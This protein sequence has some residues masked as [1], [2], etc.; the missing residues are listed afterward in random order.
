MPIWFA[1]KTVTQ[2]PR[3]LGEKLTVAD[4]IHTCLELRKYENV[5]WLPACSTNLNRGHLFV[6]FPWE[7]DPSHLKSIS[8]N[9]PSFSIHQDLRVPQDS[10]KAIKR[11]TDI[12]NIYLTL[13]LASQDIYATFLWR[14]LLAAL[15]I[16]YPNY[17][18]SLARTHKFQWVQ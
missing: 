11:Q 12:A 2:N 15:R 5:N 13:I 10:L 8:S 7:W 4:S 18:A 3:Q 9:L 17:D 6:Q 14:K 1:A 16:R